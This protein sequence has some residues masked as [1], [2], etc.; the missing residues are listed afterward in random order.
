MH[1]LSTKILKIHS[2]I[3]AFL[4]KIASLRNIAILCMALKILKESR[5]TFIL[6][7]V[8]TMEI[9]LSVFSIIFS[10]MLLYGIFKNAPAFMVPYM[11]LMLFNIVR[12]TL[13]VLLPMDNISTDM[14][15]TENTQYLSVVYGIVFFFMTYFLLV[16]WAY[17][18]QVKESLAWLRVVEAPPASV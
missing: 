3:I 17:Y 9:M 8:I 13:I 7:S 5:G 14:E 1:K 10:L 18:V 15:N 4:T 11:V 12:C 2:I 6:E 16:V